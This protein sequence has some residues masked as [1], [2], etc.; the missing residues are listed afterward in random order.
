MPKCATAARNRHQLGSRVCSLLTLSHVL[1]KKEEQR[2]EEQD[3][4][5]DIS[6]QGYA[7]SLSPVSLALYSPTRILDDV[8]GCPAQPPPGAV[9]TRDYHAAASRGSCVIVPSAHSSGWGLRRAPGDVVENTRRRVESERDGR[10]R[11]GVPLSGNVTGKV[12]LLF[13][14]FLLFREH[15]RESEE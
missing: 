2:K 9:R 7:R 4:S 13:P 3:F 11:A 14:L 12:L 1:S 6:R 15:V 8:T 5:C 10:E